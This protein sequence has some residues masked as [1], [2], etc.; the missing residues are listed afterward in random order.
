MNPK[1][2]HEIAHHVTG[3]ILAADEP[4]DGV[5]K[6]LNTLNEEESITGEDMFHIFVCVSLTMA[7]TIDQMAATAGDALIRLLVFLYPHCS[8]E[9]LATMSKDMLIG[10]YKRE[11]PKEMH[12]FVMQRK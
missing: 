7:T 8:V 4:I 11:I 5:V 6:I 2:L 3:A 10:R 12:V 9:E 1:K